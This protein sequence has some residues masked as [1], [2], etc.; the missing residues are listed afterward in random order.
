MNHIEITTTLPCINNCSYCPQGLLKKSYGLKKLRLSLDEF[1]KALENVPKDIQIHF[2]AF[3]E[4]FGNRESSQM[5]KY[6]SD[7]GYEVVVY[8]TLNGIT[9]ED[10][11]IIKDIPSKE[12]NIHLIGIEIPELPFRTTKISVTNPISRAGNLFDIEEKDTVRCS[13][14]SEFKQNV[15]L[16]NGDVYL[17]C[18]DYGLEHKIGNIFETNYNDMPREA[19]YNLCKKCEAAC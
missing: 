1:K 18:M 7:N 9:D 16:P 14:N 19:G 17:C 12:F 13:R 11:E 3:S 2:S 5:M 10:I 8:S 4:P 15:M 6:A